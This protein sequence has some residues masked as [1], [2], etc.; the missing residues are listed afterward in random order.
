MFCDLFSYQHGIRAKKPTELLKTYK[1]PNW[2]FCKKV[3]NEDHRWGIE[4]GNQ[5]RVWASNS[6]L[7]K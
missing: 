1:I 6:D 7:N 3:F 5:I 2:C 4:K